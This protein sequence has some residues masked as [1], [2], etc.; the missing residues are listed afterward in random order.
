MGFKEDVIFP[1]HVVNYKLYL[2]RIS[3]D[4]AVTM[5]VFTEKKSTSVKIRLDFLFLSLLK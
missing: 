3:K 1:K 4:E 5:M 2:F